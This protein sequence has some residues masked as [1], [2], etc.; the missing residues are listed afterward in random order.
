[1]A[2][3]IIDTGVLI[4]AYRGR[5]PLGDLVGT[6]SMAVPAV[7]VAEF[8]HGAM[9]ARNDDDAAGQ[10]TFLRD[11]LVLAP[12]VDYTVQVAQ[13]HAA[14]LTHV[15]RAGSPRGAH[16]LIVAAT[17]RAW[18]RAILTTD[19]RARFDDLP[20]VRVRLVGTG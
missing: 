6:D 19:R 8:L 9:L 1:M 10:R 4:E 20:G 2:R 7:A 15:R 11:A 17:A 14:L 5:L 16:D 3:L 12:V 13:E 18:D